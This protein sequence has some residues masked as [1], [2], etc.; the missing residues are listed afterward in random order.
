MKLM[1]T[2]P[3]V[4]ALTATIKEPCW[5]MFIR[6]R[7]DLSICSLGVTTGSKKAINKNATMKRMANSTNDPTKSVL[8]KFFPI[9]AISVPRN[10]EIKPPRR[11]TAVAEGLCS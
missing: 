3:V 2:Y 10:A 5:I 8:N 7:F 11:T 4:A 6:D 9:V 1:T